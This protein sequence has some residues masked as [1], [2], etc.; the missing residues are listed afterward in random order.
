VKF[1]IYELRNVLV[2]PVVTGAYYPGTQCK[3]AGPDKAGEAPKLDSGQTITLGGDRD[4]TPQSTPTSA[5][6]TPTT[7][8]IRRN[9]P[10]TQ[11][12]I[13]GKA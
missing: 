6:L 5:Q 8:I 4:E 3:T 1:K 10:D 13:H 7:I 2:V 9:N 11:C 12:K